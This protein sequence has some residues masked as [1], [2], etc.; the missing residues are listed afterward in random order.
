MPLGAGQLQ[1]VE[2]PL[3]PVA[4]GCFWPTAVILASNSGAK[5]S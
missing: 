1:N 4:T 3:S 5:T 2:S